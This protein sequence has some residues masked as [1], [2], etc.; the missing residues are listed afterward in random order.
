MPAKNK[1]SDLRDHL[2][3]SIERLRDETLSDAEFEKEVKRAGALSNLA[4]TVIS[5]AKLE[6]QAIDVLGQKT[7][8]A[9]LEG[10]K[11]EKPALPHVVPKRTGTK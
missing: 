2:F 7:E 9:F 1:L 11:E 4:K 8:C 3:E 10:S 6:L 5:S